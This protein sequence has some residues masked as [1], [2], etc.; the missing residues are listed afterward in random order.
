MIQKKSKV[1]WRL[2]NTEKEP[3]SAD[4]SRHERVKWLQRRN[5]AALTR[6]RGPQL[7]PRPGEGRAPLPGTRLRTSGCWRST[8]PPWE[9]STGLNPGGSLKVQQCRICCRHA[10]LTSMWA[11]Q[12]LLLQR[13]TAALCSLMAA[14]PANGGKDTKVTIFSWY[15]LRCLPFFKQA[16]A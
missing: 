9:K 4:G 12:H 2:K 1:E 3:K 8:D 14:S 15:F 7:D 13:Q 11:C 16:K 5:Q 6:R 10:A